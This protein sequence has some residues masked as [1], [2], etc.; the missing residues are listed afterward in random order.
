VAFIRHRRPSLLSDKPTESP[1]HRPFD[2]SNALTTIFRPPLPLA[3]VIKILTRVVGVV[4]DP[5][6]AAKTVFLTHTLD[7]LAAGA[8]A[9]KSEWR[10]RSL[11]REANVP[12][13]LSPA[14]QGAFIS[15]RRYS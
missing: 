12:K 4:F 9:L 7:C 14:N 2:N 13:F 15:L 1:P 3:Y 5:T 10:T 6:P 11:R 8:S